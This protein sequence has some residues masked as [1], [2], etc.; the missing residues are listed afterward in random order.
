[1]NAGHGNDTPAVSELL[2]AAE[3]DAARLAKAAKTML[4]GIKEFDVAGTADAS[5][6]AVQDEH[7]R[8]VSS[9]LARHSELT[10]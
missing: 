1:M 10:R 4:D 3:D 8:L 7:I 9:A 6:C 5:V 2:R